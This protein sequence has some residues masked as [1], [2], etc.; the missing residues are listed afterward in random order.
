MESWTLGLTAHPIPNGTPSC[1]SSGVTEASGSNIVTQGLRHAAG[2]NPPSY[3]I[4]F[5]VTQGSPS[6]V[7]RRILKSSL[8]GYCLRQVRRF[9]L[10]MNRS[11]DCGNS[12]TASSW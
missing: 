8:A 7:I 1:H 3:E 4:R 6:P 2:S 10:P 5:S 11:P 12:R 9:G